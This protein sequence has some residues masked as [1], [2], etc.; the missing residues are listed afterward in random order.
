MGDGN[1]LPSELNPLPA[2]SDVVGEM[3]LSEFSASRM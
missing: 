1:A 3:P 2:Y